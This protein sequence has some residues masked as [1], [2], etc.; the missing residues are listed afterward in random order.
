MLTSALQLDPA[1]LRLPSAK[2]NA[3]PRMWDMYPMDPVTL[4][5]IA[6][7]M[8]TLAVLSDLWGAAST[9]FVRSF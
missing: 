5:M 3:A 6:R 9:D 8:F 2:L 7:F 1:S 4:E